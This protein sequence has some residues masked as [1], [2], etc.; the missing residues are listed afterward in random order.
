MRELDNHAELLSEVKSGNSVVMFHASWCPACHQYAPEF[1]KQAGKYEAPTTKFLKFDMDKHRESLPI[2]MQELSAN[3]RAYPTLMSFKH[4]PDGLRAFVSANGDRNDDVISAMC[5]SEPI[6]TKKYNRYSD[7]GS[8][9]ME[10]NDTQGDDLIMENDNESME[11]ER[12][13]EG[14]KTM[15]NEAKEAPTKKV[16]DVGDLIMEDFEADEM[17][18][19]MD[20]TI[21]EM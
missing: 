13:M 3:V 19:A 8:A 1:E 10:E 4:T 12:D 11:T 17:E 2:H 14:H 21:M 20:E 18:D 15:E 6:L 5:D 9:K 7:G 16:P